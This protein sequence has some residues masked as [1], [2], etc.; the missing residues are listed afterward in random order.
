MSQRPVSQ[1]ATV[2]WMSMNGSPKIEL[3]ELSLSPS[4]WC[5]A[6][7]G[8]NV[9]GE[10][11]SSL[12]SHDMIDGPFCPCMILDIYLHKDFILIIEGLSIFPV[13]EGCHPHNLL[14]LVDNGHREDI[15]DHPSWIIQGPLLQGVGKELGCSRCALVRT[16]WPGWGRGRVRLHFFFL[17]SDHANRLHADSLLSLVCELYVQG[18]CVVILWA[19]GGYFPSIQTSWAHKG[20]SPHEYLLEELK[21]ELTNCSTNGS[22]F[23][24]YTGL[25]TLCSWFILSSN[26][27]YGW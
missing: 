10:G 16:W 20:S 26:M 6:K 19:R 8:P 25:W 14:F 15:L 3:W 7:Q 2:Q 9:C 17:S 22:T 18:L 24:F 27:K 21:K 23:L 4:P 1:T 12:M 11:Q 13:V 5:S